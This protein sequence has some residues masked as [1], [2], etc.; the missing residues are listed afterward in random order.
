MILKHKIGNSDRKST[1]SI[2]KKQA[3]EHTEPRV[4]NK[5]E[6]IGLEKG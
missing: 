2:P 4:V 6:T 5:T 1:K 3:L